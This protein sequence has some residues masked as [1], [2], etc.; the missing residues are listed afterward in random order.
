MEGEKH[1]WRTIFPH[2]NFLSGDPIL[3]YWF[4]TFRFSVSC[5]TEIN[6][7]HG[8]TCTYFYLGEAEGFTD[9]WLH[10]LA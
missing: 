3:F 7:G 1:R 8:K 2:F 4:V 6:I 10:C 5:V 9:V